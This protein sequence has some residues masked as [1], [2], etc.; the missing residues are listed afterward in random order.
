MSLTTA[1]LTDL[2]SG[3]GVTAH[4]SFS[5]DTSL[6]PG[7]AA[8]VNEFMMKSE[9][10]F[11]LLQGWFDGIDIPFDYPLAVDRYHAR[12]PDAAAGRAIGV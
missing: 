4:Y 9:A 8:T 7:G 11:S 6:L 2:G 5:Y 12:Q 3:Q 1:G 10:D